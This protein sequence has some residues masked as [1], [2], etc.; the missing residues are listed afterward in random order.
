MMSRGPIL[1]IAVALAA[2]IGPSSALAGSDVASTHSYIQA[3]YALV[4]AGSANRGAAA[5][6]LKALEGKVGSECPKAAAASPQNPESTQLSN[7]VIGAMVLTAYGTDTSAGTKFISATK[8]L[9]WGNQKLTKAI[10][11]YAGKLQVLSTLAVPNVCA[12]VRAW[13]ASGYRT[14]PASTV[15]F[16]KQFIPNWVGLGELPAR[17]LAPS[18]RPAQSS[19][20]RRTTHLE[21]QL[22]EFEAGDGVNT[23]AQIMDM[24]VLQP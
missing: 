8:G 21:D 19:I 6:A 5:A 13:V 12:D 15:E 24:L 1:F 14:L 9:R 4:A 7:E 20:L 2:A 3:N 11:S 18:E 22:A 17:L 16:D 23:W 10:Q